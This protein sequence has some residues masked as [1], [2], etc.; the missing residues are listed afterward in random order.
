MPVLCLMVWFMMLTSSL[1]RVLIAA[2]QVKKLASLNFISFVLKLSFSVLGYF[3]FGLIGF[4][5]GVAIGGAITYLCLLLHITY[6]IKICLSKE[7][8]YSI[9][10]IFLCFTIIIYQNLTTFNSAVVMFG[11]TFYS[12][13][14]T[15]LI[16]PHL[17][18]KA[19]GWL[20]NM[21]KTLAKNAF[22]KRI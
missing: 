3:N 7:F 14:I 10:T 9:S 22:Q 6:Y 20:F 16:S 8:K 15:Y 17:F 1:D 18:N 13:F 19:K 21:F 2:G 11:V 5:I 4:I 12:L